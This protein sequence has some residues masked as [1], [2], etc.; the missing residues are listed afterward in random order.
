VD[1]WIAER[2][3]LWLRQDDGWDVGY[4]ISRSEVTSE[5]AIFYVFVEDVRSPIGQRPIGYKFTLNAAKTFALRHR[6]TG[7]EM[8]T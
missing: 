6:V 5:V 3:D 8:E 2:P 1:R 4:R 7:Y